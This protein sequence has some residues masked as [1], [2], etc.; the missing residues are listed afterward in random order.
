MTPIRALAAGLLAGGAGAL[1][2]EPR[3]EG[4]D[5]LRL[6]ALTG[7]LIGQVLT[8]PLSLIGGGVR[9]YVRKGRPVRPAGYP[10]GVLLLAFGVLVLTQAWALANWL[11]VEPAPRGVGDPDGEA[12]IA[13]TSGLSGCLAVLVGLVV[14]VNRSGVWR[15]ARPRRKPAT[16]SPA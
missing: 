4:L 10:V 6:A 14:L 16:P 3:G 13:L 11:R 9:A 5:H 12:G 7:L 1:L 8:V 15:K 2:T